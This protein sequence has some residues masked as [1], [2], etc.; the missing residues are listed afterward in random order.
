M[1]S[2]LFKSSIP[3]IESVYESLTPSEK[4]IANFFINNTD[5]NQDVSSKT[6]ANIVHVS[7]ASLTRF[8]KKC[9]FSGYREF[10]YD[11]QS[12]QIPETVRYQSRQMKRVLLDY[13][14]I[15]D[16]TYSL[17]EV[18]QI[19][20][21][22]TRLSSAK[23]VYIY[24][25]GSSGL[26]ASEMKIR[27]MRMGLPIEAIT[28]DDVMLVN[29][30]LIDEETVVIG[31][32]ISGSTRVVLT[33]MEHATKKG[34]YTVM[35]TT[36]QNNFEEEKISE[37]I[38]VA[39]VKNLSYGNRISPQLPLLIVTDIIYDYFMELDNTNKGSIFNQS[40]QSLENKERE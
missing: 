37:I 29:H 4:E 5:E 39:S 7:E 9:G 38:P 18:E 22:A 19:E 6:I 25:K 28:D 1:V 20:R 36:Q 33:A 24:G 2:Q 26:A 14:K 27:F 21:L 3:I 12:K 30:V 11:Y 32:S 17:I 40:L 10:I 34:A 16:K 23:R 8:A 35:F 15:L 13:N 31:F